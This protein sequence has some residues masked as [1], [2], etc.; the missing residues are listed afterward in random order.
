M[1]IPFDIDADDLGTAAFLA[2]VPSTEGYSGALFQ[3][4]ARGEPVE[5][6][7]NQVSAPPSILWRPGDLRRAALRLLVSS[8]CEASPV[9]PTLLVTREA[10]LPL[11]L[12]TEDVQVNVPVLHV[13]VTEDGEI[14]SEWVL[15]AERGSA[16]DELAGTLGA[17]GLLLEPFERAAEGLKEAAVG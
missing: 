17:R 7:W 16:A 15:A 6:T 1:P 14:V 4:T 2:I 5:F 9:I 10:A 8:L 3:I 13:R 11:E 12:F